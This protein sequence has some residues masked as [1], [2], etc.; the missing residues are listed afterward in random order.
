M[1]SGDGL[2]AV[3]VGAGPNGP[4][5]AVTLAQAG[6]RHAPGVFKL[7]WAWTLLAYCH[8]PNGSRE[9]YTD[10]IEQQIERHAPGFRDHVLDRHVMPPHALEASKANLVGGDVTGGTGDMRQLLA[11]PVP[12]LRPW[13]TPVKSVYLC[14]ASTPP[15][16]GVHRMGGL[17]SAHLALR[18][19]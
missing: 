5:G 4:V 8:V 17:K 11:R 19:L 1:S 18:R 15:G 7:D 6:L 3:V 10:A 2:D 9:D 13:R 16:G 14:S 12:R